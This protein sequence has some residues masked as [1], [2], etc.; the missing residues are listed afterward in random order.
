MAGPWEKYSASPEAP[1]AGPWQKYGAPPADAP[2]ERVSGQFGIDHP[3][4]AAPVDLL[5]GV[6]AGVMSTIRG[7]SQLAHKIIPAIPEVPASYAQT[8]DSVAAKVGK[9]GEQAAEF[10]APMGMVS[11]ATKG[12][13]L[14]AR[15]AAEGLASAGVSAVQ[16][17]GDAGATAA[18]GL[19][20]AAG[21]AIGAAVGA[22][23][24]SGIPEKLYQSALKPAK[25]AVLSG[26][27]DK[28]I[29]AG[30]E[31]EIPV[32]A[33][34]AE[35]L[36][37][38]VDDLNTAI[39]DKI[40]AGARGGVT[41]DP[42]AV[43]QRADQIRGRFSSQ[44]NPAAD[45]NAIDASKAEFLAGPGAGPIPADLAQQIKQG[46]YQQIRKSYGQLSSAQVEAQKALARGIKEELVSAFP[47]I[48][49][50]NAQESKLLGLDSLLENAVARIGN[51][52][53]FGIGT[54]LAAAG[55]HAA[56]GSAPVAATAG[57]LRSIIDNPDV[58][59]RIA[60]ALTRA[61]S[62]KSATM[63]FINGRLAALQ[64][65]I[66]AGASKAAEGHGQPTGALM[67]A[68]AQQ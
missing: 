32:S 37:G 29:Q 1:P 56:T 25:K 7:A 47:E 66:E 33:K 27:A 48:A 39:K 68:G 28:A 10:V 51:Q 45:L 35:R 22:A 9:F 60:I 50:M 44:V 59:S 46:T 5:Q 8:P 17:G 3:I 16:S 43:A 64:G 41:I 58:K 49:G 53:M 4:L 65:A 38:L 57:I 40:D 20:G 26:A 31:N 63:Q 15:M 34:G 67:P 54:P 55:V 21:P 23:G 13:G 18:G 61:G 12:A 19:A 30:L 42:N 36:H 24:R 62:G 6:G 2:P 11:N 14:L 52:Q